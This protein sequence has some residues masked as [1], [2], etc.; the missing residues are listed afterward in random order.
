[1]SRPRTVGE[2]RRSVSGPGVP[3]KEEMRRNLLRKL[4]AGKALFP[5]ILGY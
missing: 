1:M 4:S 3:V 5:G 2:L